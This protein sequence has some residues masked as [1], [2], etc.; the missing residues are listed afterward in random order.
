MF[1]DFIS[2]V[3]TKKKNDHKKNIH[4]RK[5]TFDKTY[6]LP[7]Q[8]NL[9]STSLCNNPSN[10]PLNSLLNDSGNSTFYHKKKVYLRNKNKLFELNI[11]TNYHG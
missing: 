9:L 2:S 7:L 6:P 3:L 10:S 8:P 5:T 4:A 11:K 1:F